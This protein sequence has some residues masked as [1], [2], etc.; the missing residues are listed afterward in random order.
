LQL[1]L[2]QIIGCSVI[3]RASLATNLST[4]EI[5]YV[6]GAIIVLFNPKT[7]R[8]TRFL[9]TANYRPFQSVVFSENGKYLAAGE[10]S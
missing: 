5:A 3:N 1:S 10:A 9:T 7:N 8:Q 2:E 4:G 6:A